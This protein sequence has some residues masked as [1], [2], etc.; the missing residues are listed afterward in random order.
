MKVTEKKIIWWEPRAARR[1][2][3]SADPTNSKLFLC[4]TFIFFLIVFT[5]IG[6]DEFGFFWEESEPS[7]LAEIIFAILFLSLSITGAFWGAA[8]L[9][10]EIT[11]NE[12]K[13]TANAILERGFHSDPYH[14]IKKIAIVS[15]RDERS[16]YLLLEIHPHTGEKS[17][18]G[19][20]AESPIDVI[21]SFLTAKKVQVEII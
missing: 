12:K 15:K 11:L 6:V 20:S 13:L 7:K 4:G 14:S 21:S 2:L 18:Y 8:Y 16:R 3:E 5:L 19:I 17:V 10:N 1:Y 9:P